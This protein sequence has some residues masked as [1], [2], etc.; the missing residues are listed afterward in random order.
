MKQ[1]LHSKTGPRR[2]A[3][4]ASPLMVG[5]VNTRVSS[6]LYNLTEN[7]SNSTGGSSSLIS[8]LQDE[9][10][11]RDGEGEGEG[12][13]LLADKRKGKIEES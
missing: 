2:K 8:P 6:P 10:P 1:K 11:F 13:I 4:H 12:G 3:T 5:N 7:I 9:K